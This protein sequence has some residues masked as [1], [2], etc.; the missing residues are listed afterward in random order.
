[1]RFFQKRAYGLRSIISKI[2]IITNH[3]I[4]FKITSKK[5]RKKND[6]HFFKTFFLKSKLDIYFCP[7]L[8]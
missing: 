1:M 6:F 5:K 4:F 3:V 2:L 7:F 8:I